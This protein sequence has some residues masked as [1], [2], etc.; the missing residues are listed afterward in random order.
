MVCIQWQHA[1]TFDLSY[2]ISAMGSD[3]VINTLSIGPFSEDN[4]TA[5]V[6]VQITDDERAEN[7]ELFMAMLVAS[8]NSPPLLVIEPENTT[9]TIL[10]N[11]GENLSIQQ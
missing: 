3:Y 1:Y 6:D 2:L 8:S 7:T 4:R 5:C 10:D 9:V 11:D